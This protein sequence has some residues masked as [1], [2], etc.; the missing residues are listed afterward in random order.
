MSDNA[1]LQKVES[2]LSRASGLPPAEEIQAILLHLQ[3]VGKEPP[4]SS[5]RQQLLEGLHMRTRGAIESLTPRLYNVRLPISNNTRQTVRNMQETLDQLAR[6]GLQS[7]ESPDSQLIKGLGTPVDLAL[8][9]IFEALTQHLTLSNLIA[10]PPFPGTWLNL[11]R[12]Y[13]AAWQHRAEHRIPTDTPYDLQ[14]LYARALIS[15]A[16]APS[17]L[18]ASEWA[19]LHRFLSQAK[20]PLTITKGDSPPQL[21][22][23]LWVSP[24][25]DSAP[26]LLE[27]RPPNENNHAFFVSCSAILEEIKQA[28][29]LLA[30]ESR[31]P[32]FLPTDTPLR[33]ARIA[34]RQLADHLTS[35]KKRRFSR[36]RQGYRATMCVGF[37][38]IC[39]LLKSGS[40]Q[41]DLL[42]EWM[43]VNES[44]GGYAAMHVSGRPRKAQVGDLVAICREG[45]SRWGINV[46]RWALSEN[47][48]HLEFGLEEL[49]P[50]AVSGYMATPG[51]LQGGHPLALLLPAIPPLRMVD[52][53]AFSP[54]ARPARD[55]NHVFVSDG[56]RAEIRE[57]RLGTSIE[58]SSGIDVCLMESA[59]AKS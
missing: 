58:Q 54:T 32:D 56:I 5:R 16:V 46:V 41:N 27:R 44:P 15:G 43:V 33:T 14:T 25:S 45:E 17:A 49:A 53:L 19:F 40:V 28:L 47:P 50:Q 42:S 35:P 13:Q 4:S 37:D 7:V 51:Q 38:E 30:Q 11:H 57:F 1:N 29:S 20:S 2:W 39:G 8:W 26:V 34:L 48:E 55:Q 12:A 10:T 6:L 23:T 24:S 22:S 18:S 21:E 36:R 52:A 59:A 3:I 31:T 9:R